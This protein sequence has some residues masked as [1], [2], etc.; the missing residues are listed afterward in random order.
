MPLSLGF[1][2]SVSGPAAVNSRARKVKTLIW[3]L[4]HGPALRKVLESQLGGVPVL[5]IEEYKAPV[6]CIICFAKLAAMSCFSS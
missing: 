5:C 6:C 4:P 3:S 1:G 2:C